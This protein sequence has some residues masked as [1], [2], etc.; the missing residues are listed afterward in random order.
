PQRIELLSAAH[1]AG[2][3]GARPERDSQGIAVALALRRDNHGIVSAG[4][5][6]VEGKAVDIGGGAG[7][8]RVVSRCCCNDHAVAQ[9]LRE[10]NDSLRHRRGAEDNEPVR[11]YR[12]DEN[13]DRATA[14]THRGMELDPIEIVL[15]GY[16]VLG[17][18]AD[19]LGFAAFENGERR[20]SDGA[21]YAM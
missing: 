13:F 5:E 16:F 21:G 10:R 9:R 6:I 18:D 19:E 14:Q 8:F 1:H 12:L 15:A 11:F 3:A 4:L 7:N 20:A 2:I 17:P